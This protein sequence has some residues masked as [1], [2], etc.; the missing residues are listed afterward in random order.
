MLAFNQD[1]A[2]QFSQHLLLL[3]NHAALALMISIGHRSKLF[4]VMSTMDAANSETIAQNA[5]LNERYVRE[6]LNAMVTGGIIDYDTHQKLYSLPAEHAAFLTRAASPNNIAVIAQFIPI[7]ANVEDLILNAFIHGGG[8]PYEAYHR[9]HSVMAEQSGQTIY[10]ALLD[11]IIPLVNG[12]REQLQQG[13][14]VLDI[15]CG[16]GRALSLMAEHF[17]NSQF[18]GF[19]LC[20][21]TIN[22]A[23]A[24]ALQKGLTNLHFMR[25]D[26]AKWHEQNQYDLITSFDVIHDQA[27]PKDVLKAV[28]EALKPQGV[29]LM[30]DIKT[31]SQV[32]NNTNHP[33]APLI[34]TIS[35]LH[36]MTVSLSQNGAGLGAA[37]GEELAEEML[38]DA[39][40]TQIEKRYLEHD[41][42]NTYYIVHK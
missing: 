30:Q 40:F 35:C 6:W 34:Y 42:M 7:L 33:I 10:L 24:L 14:K 18:Y 41:I 22:H 23:N 4:D 39:G 12:L 27:H 28:Y 31:S 29:F 19:D 8:V 38:K 11:K 2:E 9:F 16:Y 15:G 37:W 17:P 3:L 32:E 13:I 20:E 1:K 21:E 36:C 25:R 26:L 5:N